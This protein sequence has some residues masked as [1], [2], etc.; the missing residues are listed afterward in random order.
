MIKIFLEIFFYKQPVYKFF[1]HNNENIVNLK[2]KF[3]INNDLK[4][5]IKNT[6]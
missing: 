3:Q 5:K 6:Y 2:R 4:K 1:V